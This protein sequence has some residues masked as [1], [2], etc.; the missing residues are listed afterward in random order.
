MSPY[1]EQCSTGSFDG[2]FLINISVVQQSEIP[3]FEF[4]VFYAEYG[5]GT[6]REK[7]ERKVA[8][9]REPVSVDQ[10]VCY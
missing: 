7:T 4:K 3:V 2:L 10:E 1:L 8:S 5:R 9:K 6:R